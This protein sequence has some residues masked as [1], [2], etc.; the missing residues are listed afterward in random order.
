MCLGCFIA[1]TM[2]GQRVRASHSIFT[3]VIKNVC[4]FCTKEQALSIL[5]DIPVMELPLYINVKWPFQE[6]YAL[7]ESRLKTA[8]DS[9]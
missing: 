3:K 9:Q 5:L 6:C 1:D 4:V 8:G 7:I 2:F